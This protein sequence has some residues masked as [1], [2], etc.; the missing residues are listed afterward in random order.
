MI[1]AA[2]LYV[3]GYCHEQKAQVQVTG[4]NY[5]NGVEWVADFASQLHAS[6][7]YKELIESDYDVTLNPTMY[8]IRSEQLSAHYARIV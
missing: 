1:H 5:G 8:V 2:I 7:C 6:V 4:P 3:V